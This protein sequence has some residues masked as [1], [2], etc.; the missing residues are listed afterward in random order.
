MPAHSLSERA[1]R[2]ALAA[3]FAPGHLAEYTLLPGVE[4][5]DEGSVHDADE[6]WRRRPRRLVF[7]RG[8]R[9]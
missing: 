2:A 7:R 5:A 4:N 1:A 3:H 6:L 8:R 9:R